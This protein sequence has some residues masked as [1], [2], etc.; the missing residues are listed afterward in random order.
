[1]NGT[2]T[3]SKYRNSFLCNFSIHIK[4]D[5]IKCSLITPGI[6]SLLL[7]FMEE[8]CKCAKFAACI[9]MIWFVHTYWNEAKNGGKVE[10]NTH[11][12]V[13]KMLLVWRQS[14]L[15]LRSTSRFHFQQY[16]YTYY[17]LTA[18]LYRAFYR[19]MDKDDVNL[20]CDSVENMSKGISFHALSLC[21]MMVFMWII[22]K[23][24]TPLF[25]SDS[26]LFEMSKLSNGQLA[27][28]NVPLSIGLPC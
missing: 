14:S 5:Y 13:R 2:K 23:R 21:C 28:Y 15:L 25:T 4:D 3:S 19:Y 18:S 11:F 20:F 9:E 1:M 10:K 16:Q 17:M 24:F 7:C 6:K 26:I 27:L 12:I 22:L 8:L